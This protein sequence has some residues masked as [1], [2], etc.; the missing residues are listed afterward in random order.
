[1]TDFLSL[2]QGGSQKFGDHFD[3]AELRPGDELRVVTGHTEYRFAM[4][5]RRDADLTC[6][7]PDRPHTRARIMGC[8][9]GHSSSIK[10]DHLFCGGNL[11][12]SYQLDGKSMTHR[13]TAIKAIY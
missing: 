12:F 4:L 9:F 13:T 7:R 2:A 8:T 1:M 6:S 10:P 3:L 5:D 11:E